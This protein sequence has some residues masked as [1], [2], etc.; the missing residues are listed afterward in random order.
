L[1]A[2][3]LR[4]AAAFLSLFLILF[5]AP[6]AVAC[7]TAA[8][9]ALAPTFAAPTLP[10]TLLIKATKFAGGFD[11]IFIHKIFFIEFKGFPL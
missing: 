9:A 8:A 3:D 4:L 10:P 7:F 5:G 1:D 2:P 6:T 11:I